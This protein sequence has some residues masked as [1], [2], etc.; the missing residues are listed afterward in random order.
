MLTGDLHNSFAI[1]ITD[2]VW[3]FASGPHNSMNHP[4]GSEANRPANGVFDSQGRKADIR[5][6]SYI[7]SDTPNH[8]RKRP[9]YCVVSR[10]PSSTTR[11][12]RVLTLGRLPA[13]A[14]R[15]PYYDGLTGELLYAES[16]VAPGAR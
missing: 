4:A 16:I 14:G 11:A 8:M 13:P 2:R 12:K 6:S 15:L 5:W 7:L 9:V 3:E 1:K 10:T